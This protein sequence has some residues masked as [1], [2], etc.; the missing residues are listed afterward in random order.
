MRPQIK[1][2]TAIAN[3]GIA[4]SPTLYGRRT[5][6]LIQH[7]KEKKPEEYEATTKYS[8]FV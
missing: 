8:A 1:T 5:Q 3:P 2:T 6:S 4:R 7:L